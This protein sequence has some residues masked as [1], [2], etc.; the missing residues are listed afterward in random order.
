MEHKP[1][2]KEYLKLGSEK[3]VNKPEVVDFNNIEIPRKDN[4][5][6]SVNKIREF[7]K[8]IKN[9]TVT[10]KDLGDKYQI[11]IEINKNTN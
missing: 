9:S 1:E 3:Q 6:D 8:N 4:Y 11:I 10:E 2:L 7:T 5:N